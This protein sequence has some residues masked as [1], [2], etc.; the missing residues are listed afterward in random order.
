MFA[1]TKCITPH[2]LAA[3]SRTDNTHAVMESES[4]SQDSVTKYSVNVRMEIDNCL[5]VI[6]KLEIIR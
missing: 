1:P 3:N 4:F 2:A 6:I 5:Y